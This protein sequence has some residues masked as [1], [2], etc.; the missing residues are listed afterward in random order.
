MKIVVKEVEK[1]LPEEHYLYSIHQNIFHGKVH[2]L[3]IYDNK[4]SHLNHKPQLEL[5]KDKRCV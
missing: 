1:H 2:E 5:K 3:T 4:K